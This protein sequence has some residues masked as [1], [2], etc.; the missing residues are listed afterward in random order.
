[1]LSNF[2]RRMGLDNWGNPEDSPNANWTWAQLHETVVQQNPHGGWQP[3]E[4]MR[5]LVVAIKRLHFATLILNIVL[6]ALT[7]GIFILAFRHYP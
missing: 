3:I 7:A 2:R 1:M 4:A 5:R 6:I